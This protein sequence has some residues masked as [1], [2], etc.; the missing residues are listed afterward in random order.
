ME[1]QE[2]SQSTTPVTV[3]GL[4]AMGTAL[5]RAFLHG[6]H[7]TTVW[8]RT[9][10]KVDILVAE[11]ATGAA[12]VADAV[13]PS[14]LLIACVLDYP[15][16]HVTLD[17]VGDMLAGRA[18]VNLTNGTPQQ[19]REMGSWAAAHDAEYLDG[20]IMAVP[21]MI[22]QPEAVLLYS[23]SRSTF[24]SHERDL[25]RLGTGKYLGADPGLASLHDLALLSG[26][27]GMFA[28]AL[29][30][31]AL[32]GTENIRATDLVPLLVPWV[33]AMTAQLPDLARQIDAR[34]YTLDT[35][36]NLQMQSV[37]FVNIGNASKDQ[38]VSF[39]LL[40]PLQALVE[41]RVRDGHGADDLSGLIELIRKPAER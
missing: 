41:R 20:G 23:G 14:K 12:T 32:V 22:A 24:E 37:G 19:A 1:S 7:P 3:I 10:E 13:A 31:F 17:P 5:A 18:I 16:A 40:A 39:E 21:P 2:Q 4:G 25:A 11:G 35:A 36:A 28:G 29:H 34:D 9:K 15:A 33:T 30:A 27:Y 26:M 8:N 6:G 38:G